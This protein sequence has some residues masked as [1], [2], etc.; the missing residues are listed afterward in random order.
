[1]QTRPVPTIVIVH[2]S[3]GYDRQASAKRG[4]ERTIERC[5]PAMVLEV[6][7]PKR[8]SYLAL[9]RINKFPVSGDGDLISNGFYKIKAPWLKTETFI[10]CGGAV[11][12]CLIHAFISVLLFRMYTSDSIFNAIK[13]GPDPDRPDFLKAFFASLVKRGGTP[14]LN[15]HFNFEGIYPAVED[16]EAFSSDAM[17]VYWST[18]ILWQMMAAMVERHR[19]V[20]GSSG[21][22]ISELVNGRFIGANP[23]VG[24]S[25]V[26]LFYWS[27]TESMAPHI[28]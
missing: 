7:D 8:P 22:N 11:N 2:A 12:R 6:E 17:A 28:A 9:S 18:N 4:I 27:D 21:L 16:F 15:F 19:T 10:F 24:P 23:P 5:V 3:R 20:L 26:N 13:Y 14:P 25:E 1:M